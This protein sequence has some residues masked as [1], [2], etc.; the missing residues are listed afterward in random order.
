MNVDNVG[1]IVL[2]IT[3]CLYSLAYKHRVR[4]QGEM[5]ANSINSNSKLN[6]SKNSNSN[7]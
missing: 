1:K 6:L 4:H 3:E 7:L 5:G 2:S